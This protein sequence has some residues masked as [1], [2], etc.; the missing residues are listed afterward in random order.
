MRELS[1]GGA[2]LQARSIGIFNFCFYLVSVC[3]FLIWPR[4]MEK[5]EE[6]VMVLLEM[7]LLCDINVI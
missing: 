3:V 7:S 2:P 4:L 5:K 6:V 1:E